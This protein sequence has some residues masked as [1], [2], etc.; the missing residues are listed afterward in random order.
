MQAA[1]AKGKTG[2]AARGHK[3]DEHKERAR[4]A[5]KAGRM[6]EAQLARAA[7]FFQQQLV[8]AGNPRSE[9]REIYASDWRDRVA[10]R[11]WD[12]VAKCMAIVD[13]RNSQWKALGSPNSEQRRKNPA[14]YVVRDMRDWDEGLDI[15]E[16]EE[17][18]LYYH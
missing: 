11:G 14:K 12:F 5:V 1:A 16:D 10:E 2:A 4:R 9:V 13:A 8:K 6:T 15:E 7:K 17:W 3:P 18:M